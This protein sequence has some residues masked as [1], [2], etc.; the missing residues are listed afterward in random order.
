MSAVS[1]RT[2]HAVSRLRAAE[3]VSFSGR[4]TRVM[5]TF[6]ESDGPH[7]PVGTLCELRSNG[8]NAVTAEIASINGRCVTLMP[9]D[10][11][12]GV[13]I[14][15]A[16]VARERSATAEVGVGLLGR[17]LDA[18]GR[19]ID[20]EGPIAPGRP[21]PLHGVRVNPLNRVTSDVVLETGIRAID[22]LLTLARGQRVGIF[23]GSGV[24]KTTLLHCLAR[25]VEADVRVVCLVGERGRE[26][27]ELWHRVLTPAQRSRTVLVVTTA[28]EA[29]IV[30]VRA[31]Y[32]A[33]AV[34]ES[35]RDEGQHV[36][37][38]L[39]SL[40]RLAMALREVG[41]AAG[42]P[43]TVRA[44]T[45]SVF[46]ALPHVIE[47]CGAVR[48]GGAITAIASV[49]T[50]SDDVDDPLAETLKALLDGHIVLSR[51]LAE[52]G[53]LPAIDVQRS[54]SR[55][56]RAVTN[57]S[58]QSLAGDAVSQLAAY[59]SAR[60]LIDSGMYK[61]GS[62]PLVDRAIAKREHLLEYL[63]QA[64]GERVPRE[65]ALSDLHG[66]LNREGSDV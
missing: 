59:E 13:R 55:L 57:V 29:A 49:L 3:L 41:L 40:T 56:F 53:Q 35:F 24:G 47:R 8:H 27:E 39:D 48:D 51:E 1:L 31:V 62:N 54:V 28:D 26:V 36:F 45:P 33:L 23:A 61:G 5:P 11:V 63:R 4:V 15:D 30:R 37:F 44:Y 17:V 65:R 66:L 32:L 6:V 46:A 12:F 58:E 19:P 16:V 9:Y 60:A 38:V 7:A 42:E 22:G 18:R 20:G 10:P 34:A 64:P 21:R 25:N 43:P 50:E 2:E 14:G 52:R